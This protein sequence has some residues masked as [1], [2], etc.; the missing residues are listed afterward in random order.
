MAPDWFRDLLKM[1][2]S[3]DELWVAIQHN[4]MYAQL[5]RKAWERWPFTDQPG[6]EAVRDRMWNNPTV[7]NWTW[8]PYEQEE[9]IRVRGMP[10]PVDEFIP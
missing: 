1:P 2:L 6:A 4:E 10:R 8:S 9:I 3:A 7:R 5:H